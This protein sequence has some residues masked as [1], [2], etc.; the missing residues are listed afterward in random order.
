G[1]HFWVGQAMGRGIKVRIM[2]KNSNILRTDGC[3]TTIL[4]ARTGL[5][6]G[7]DIPQAIAKAKGD[8]I[9][10]TDLD[11]YPGD[12]IINYFGTDFFTNTIDYMLALAIYKGAT[13]IK[14]YGV[15]ILHAKST[16][17]IT[18]GPSSKL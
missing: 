9:P 6:Y 11:N 10:Y 12:E 4:R 1:I 2:D 16:K 14:M 13:E 5:I 3:G 15:S 7:Y 18:K 8:N 17:G